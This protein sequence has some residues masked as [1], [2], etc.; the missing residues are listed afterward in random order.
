ME[1]NQPYTNVHTTDADLEMNAQS[2]AEKNFNE[3][4]RLGF[5][6][7]VY[8]IL[9][10][11]LSLTVLLISLAFIKEVAIFLQ[12]HMAIFWTCV[13]MSLV[14]A[15]PLICC[16]NIARK[17]P[18]NYILLSLWTLCEGYMLATCASYYDPKV[19]ITAGGL[20]ALVTI[21]LTVYACTTKTDFTFCGGIL[22][23]LGALMLG[24]CIFAFAFGIYL[25]AFFCVLGVF[26]YSIY[27]IYDT[28]LIMGSFG[29]AY[30]IDDYIVAAMMIYIDI[31][32]IF[33]YLLR[34]FG[35][36]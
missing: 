11:Q 30:S 16:K 35:R 3:S 21:A 23:V 7:K 19:V 18:T 5:I 15:I 25:N 32:Q 10:A 33:L 8:G 9:A 26:L 4:M 31:I 24:Y 17:V 13:G 1:S 27:L 2:A 34:L 20:T 36:N 12:T 29:N 28:Q 6:R 22:F 14:I